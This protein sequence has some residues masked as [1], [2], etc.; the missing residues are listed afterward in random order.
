LKKTWRRKPGRRKRARQEIDG[1]SFNDHNKMV[2]AAMTKLKLLESVK[3]V[4]NNPSYET[5]KDFTP[6][7]LDSLIQ[8]INAGLTTLR[9][10]RDAQ[11]EREIELKVRQE[12]ERS[13]PKSFLVAHQ[14]IPRFPQATPQT[15]PT[16]FVPSK[17]EEH[18][19]DGEEDQG[20]CIVC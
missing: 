9:A 16:T 6:E 3:N 20:T 19:T 17:T 1:S 8:R 10:Q 7:F 5:T 14:D 12:Y 4:I 15:I 13:Q 2:I 11:K 18:Q